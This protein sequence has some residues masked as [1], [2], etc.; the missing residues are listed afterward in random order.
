MTQF[1]LCT[2]KAIDMSEGMYFRPISD[3][4]QFLTDAA[5]SLF[6][7]E[8]S[9]RV[10]VLVGGPSIADLFTD[11]HNA[12]YNGLDYSTTRLSIV[13]PELVRSCKSFA[14]WWGDDWSDLPIC[15]TDGSITLEL[16]AQLSEPIGEVYLR[17]QESP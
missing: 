5:R 9:I 13:I 3:D 4:D 2:P 14:L 8:P 11:A 17:W 15:R 6:S 10:P 16:I 1:V 7:G 12:V